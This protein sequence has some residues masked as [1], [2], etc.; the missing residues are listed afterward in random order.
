MNIAI[1]IPAYNPDDRLE[2]LVDDL[3]ADGF[4]KIIVINDGSRA[5]CLPVFD[6]IKAS[7]HAELLTHAVNM[8]KG[9]ALKTGF[10]RVCIEYP[11]C[12]GVVTA[13]ADGQHTLK[14]IRRV[15]EALEKAPNSLILGARQFDKDVPWRSMF[16]NKMTRVLMAIF[17][18]LRITDTQTGLRGIPLVMMPDLLDV[19]YNRYEFELEM[20]LLAKRRGFPISEVVIETIYLEGNA[21]S[22]FNPVFDSA[23]IYFVL[24]R[25]VLASIVTAA[26]DYIVFFLVSP[27]VGSY[28]GL[29]FISRGASVLVNYTLVRN[30]VFSSRERVLATFPKYLALV[31]VSG[32]ISATIVS[33]LCGNFAFFKGTKGLLLAKAIAEGLLYLANFVIQRDLIFSAS[34]KELRSTD[35]DEYY[36]EPYRLAFLSRFFTKRRLMGLLSKWKPRTA[37]FALAELGGADSCFFDSVAGTFKPDSYHVVDSNKLGLEKLAE[38]VAGMDVKGFKIEN[39]DV[40]A[41][42]PDFSADVV[43]SVG[44]VEHFN[45]L[46]TRK[47]VEAHFDAAKQGGI[48]IILFPTPTFLYKLSRFV[49]ELLHMWI[50]HDERPLRIEEVESCIAPRGEILR[51]GVIWGSLLTQAYIVARR[52]T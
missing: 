29:T 17:L 52:R 15:G 30:M 36:S 23:K 35:W 34:Q 50:F 38:R 41:M 14:D 11:G 9:A 4:D 46:G 48:V 24:F 25:Y 16:G 8:G 3:A 7:G 45:P 37:P 19:P 22:H 10:D 5:D 39:A 32:F 6:R 42:K 18:G 13:D 12:A 51:K 20:L 28:L 1:L 26:V 2:K 40:T 47:A 33:Y 21:S 43:F 44:L 27:F 49:S 31:A